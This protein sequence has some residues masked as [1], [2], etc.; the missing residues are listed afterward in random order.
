VLPFGQLSWETFERLCLRL[1][2]ESRDA[3]YARLYGR[4]GQAQEGI[5]IYVRRST[6]R[7]EVWQSKRYERFSAAKIEKAVDTFVN[8]AW[9]ERSDTFVLCV[10][11][12]LQDTKQQDEIERQLGRR[13]CGKNDRSRSL[14]R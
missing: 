3:R 14:S 11:A 1:A 5:D 4:R 9:R 12:P 8:A 7:Y 6:G 10:R 13:V 2:A